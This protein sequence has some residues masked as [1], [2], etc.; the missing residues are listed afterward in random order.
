LRPVP[1]SKLF[2]EIVA[3]ISHRAQFACDAYACGD[4][5]AGLSLPVL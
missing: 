5:R 4:Q 2:L 3:T 1:G